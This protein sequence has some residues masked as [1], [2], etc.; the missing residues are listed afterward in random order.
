MEQL[1]GQSLQVMPV[2]AIPVVIVVLGL[3]WIYRKT[4]II[5]K[6][7]ELTKKTRDDDSQKMHDEILKLQFKVAEL[8]GIVVLHRDK[9][10]SIEKQLGVVNSE[11]VKLNVQVGHLVKALEDQNRIMMEIRK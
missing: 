11:L 3:Y 1:I 7:R 9:L 10:D 8:D 4:M 6:D 5:Q 2:A